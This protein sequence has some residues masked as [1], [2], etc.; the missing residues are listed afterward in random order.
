MSVQ[1][2]SVTRAAVWMSYF[3]AK[4]LQE[5]NSRKK[6]QGAQAVTFQTA[7]SFKTSM[8]KNLWGYTIPVSSAVNADIDRNIYLN[9][10]Q[11]KVLSA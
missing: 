1:M 4:F 9:D 7:F 8:A 10:T 2:M 3:M 5:R 6:L 11:V